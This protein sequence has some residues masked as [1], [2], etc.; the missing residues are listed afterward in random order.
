MLMFCS[1]FP[2][3]VL[4]LSVL[5]LVACG[6]GSG[7][8]DSGSTFVPTDPNTVFQLF[9]PGGPTVGESSTVNLSGTDNFGDSWTASGSSQVQAD[10]TFLGESV[11]PTL[12]ILNLTYVP[13]GAFVNVTSTSYTRYDAGAVYRIGISD[14]ST[15]TVSFIANPVP[16]TAKIGDLG[17]V[18]TYTNN[19][20]DVTTQTWEIADAGSGR[21][22][23][24]LRSSTVD[25]FSTL[26]SSSVDTTVILP[27]GTT[28]STIV[29]VTLFNPDVVITLSD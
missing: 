19:V 26:I 15:T 7:G 18:G 20:G 5:L 29:E 25:Q 3:F 17:I 11:R 9:P 23:A 4:F 13:T 12:T 6:G 21:A 27:D 22:K 16:Y 28:V 8:S 10:T 1:P 14:T 24:I 2:K